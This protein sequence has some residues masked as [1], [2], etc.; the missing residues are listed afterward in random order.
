[1]KRGESSQQYNT[2][3]SKQNPNKSG[4]TLQQ[5]TQSINPKPIQGTPGYGISVGNNGVTLQTP[6][7]QTT[8]ITNSHNVSA[9]INNGELQSS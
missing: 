4:Q 2:W 7:G 6:N 5:A 1:M 3:L 8:D 9:L